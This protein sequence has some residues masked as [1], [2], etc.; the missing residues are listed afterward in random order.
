MP[1]YFDPLVAKDRDTLKLV[2]AVEGAW[3]ITTDD[4]K[5][6][7]YNGSE[8]I[9]ME[10][11]YAVTVQQLGDAIEE[12]LTHDRFEQLDSY[13]LAQVLLTM[14]EEEKADGQR[15]G[16]GTR[17]GAGEGAGGAVHDHPA[18]HDQRPPG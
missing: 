18:Q 5:L 13:E 15:A 2:G 11:V 16:E 8:W 6:F 12:G 4:S 14:I 1:F 7:V 17:S 10:H 3:A 9:E